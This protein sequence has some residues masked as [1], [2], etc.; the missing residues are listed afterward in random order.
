MTQAA[1]A[2]VQMN[3]DIKP[4]QPLTWRHCVAA[5]IMVAATIA[6][7]WDTWA[8]TFRLAFRDE[9]TNYVLAAP[10]V[11]A[12]LIWEK[13]DG[14]RRC[15]AG[16][17][18]L[19][20]ALIA[21]GWFLWSWGY[22][23]HAFIFVHAGPVFAAAG[24]LLCV[25]GR[26][27]IYEFLPAFGALFFLMPLTP[28]RRLWFAMP[29]QNVTARMTLAVCD[30]VGMSVERSGSVLTING[31]DVAIAEA[32]NGMRMVITLFIVCYVMAFGTNLKGFAR[33]LVLLISPAVA[34]LAN[35]IRLVPTVW[36]FGNRS[37]E[38]AEAFHTY[39]GWAML[40]I[41][42]VLLRILISVL[43]WA[44]ARGDPAVQAVSV[45]P[46][47]ALVQA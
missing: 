25:L 17:T 41:A 34:V 5:G 30:V 46:N 38:A 21:L 19:G 28:Y 10:L 12:W 23:H 15:G 33:I 42:F 26:R 31:Q 47:K 9:E 27:T 22:R 2:Q 1:N 20:P 45:A 43:Q 16:G 13:R 24:A 4:V 39:G 36:M 35:V 40:V 3:P 8:D 18:V 11:I 29:M 37:Q 44:G 14:L 7:T 32:C 6:I